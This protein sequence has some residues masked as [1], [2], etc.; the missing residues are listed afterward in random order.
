M[1]LF[2]PIIHRFA[3]PFPHYYICKWGGVTRVQVLT[4]LWKDTSTFPNSPLQHWAHQIVGHEKCQKSDRKK[5]DVLVPSLHRT[6]VSGTRRFVPTTVADRISKQD[7]KTIWTLHANL[8]HH[9]PNDEGRCTDRRFRIKASRLTRCLKNLRCG[10]RN[11]L[12][13]PRVR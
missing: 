13:R 9:K 12:Y 10:T 11:P 4:P 6:S 7:K 5:W 1:P 8:H 3:I 2:F